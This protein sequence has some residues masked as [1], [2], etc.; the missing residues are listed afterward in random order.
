M[1]VSANHDHVPEAYDVSARSL[2]PMN[3]HV[4][5]LIHTDTEV[6]QNRNCYCGIINSIDE[7]F[8]CTGTYGRSFHLSCV[9]FCQ[10]G[11]DWK[12]NKCAYTTTTSIPS[13]PW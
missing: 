13:A 3:M 7:L 4:Q 9:N 10:I 2:V 11:L 6:I 12:Y 5:A 8:S 1:E